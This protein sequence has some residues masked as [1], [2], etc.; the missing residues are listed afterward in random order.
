MTLIVAVV[1]TVWWLMRS[2]PEAVAVTQAPIDAGASV[3]APAGALAD[4]PMSADPAP[5]GSGTTSAAGAAS[6]LVVDVAGKVVHPGIY[7]LP[8]GSRV[9]DAVAAAGGVRRGVDTVTI[10]LAAPVQDG[11]Q[12]VVGLNTGPPGMAAN[13]GATSAPSTGAVVDLNT[14][15]LEVLD[16]LPGVGPVLAQNILDWRDQHGQFTSVDQLQEVSGIGPAKFAA[17]KDLVTL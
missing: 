8:A 5:D 7:R 1:V 12:I 13:P 11:Q 9:F 17:I 3:S 16:T 10:N 4:L 15:G 14:A 2:R 6:Q